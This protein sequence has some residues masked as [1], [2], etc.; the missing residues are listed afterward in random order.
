MCR[1]A[2]RGIAEKIEYPRVVSQGGVNHRM[3]ELESN[4][5]ANKE[6]P[7]PGGNR[8]DKEVALELMKFVATVT[9][10][11]KAGQGSAGFSGKPQTRSAEEH[12]EALLELY[13][14]C[15]RVVA[16]D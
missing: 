10:Y 2:E 16:K 7:T 14:R 1:T 11:G 4:N 12:A 3:A 8:N 13:E 6:A 15:R 5:A 9:G